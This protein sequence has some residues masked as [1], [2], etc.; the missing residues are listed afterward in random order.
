MSLKQKQ[1]VEWLDKFVSRGH[2]I[3]VFLMLPRKFLKT[4]NSVFSILTAPLRGHAGPIQLNLG[5]S[6]ISSMG[7]T[8]NRLTRNRS[9][10]VE[11]KYICCGSEIELL[12]K[13]GKMRTTSFCQANGL[14]I[15]TL[16]IFCP[17]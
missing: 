6:R 8:S 14:E 10:I 11:S 12:P 17:S 9:I 15:V 13:F 16:S 1:L 5:M 3:L 4:F 2:A 7:D